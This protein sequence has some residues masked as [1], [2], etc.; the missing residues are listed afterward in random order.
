MHVE[1]FAAFVV[2]ISNKHV[3]SYMFKENLELLEKGLPN[4]QKHISNGAKFGI[5]V[6]VAINAFS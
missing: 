1:K 5:P 4:L 3:C 6:V 2:I